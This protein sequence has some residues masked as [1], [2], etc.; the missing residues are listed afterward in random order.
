MDG[1][2]CFEDIVN[3]VSFNSFYVRKVFVHKIKLLEFNSP[4]SDLIKVV[5]EESIATFV[6]ERVNILC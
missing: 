6:G 2:T 5:I 3:S 1:F 4:W